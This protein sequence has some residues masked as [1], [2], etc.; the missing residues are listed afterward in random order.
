MLDGLFDRKF[1]HL[2]KAEVSTGFG[3]LVF[4]NE[5]VKRDPRLGA[6]CVRRSGRLRR[7]KIGH[8]QPLLSAELSGKSAVAGIVANFGFL[9]AGAEAGE[10]IGETYVEPGLRRRIISVQQHQAESTDDGV[11][12]LRVRNAG[13]RQVQHDEI[14]LAAG[15][16]KPGRGL[17]CGRD[18]IVF[19]SGLESDDGQRLP[20]MGAIA[21]EQVGELSAHLLKTNEHFMRGR[22]VRIGQDGEMTGADENPAGRLVAG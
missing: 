18:P 8:A 5:V 16:K 17:A 7:K 10:I 2:H 19:V 21:A 3:K 1:L 14:A 11:P 12:I 13:T 9:R 15:N 20:H 6:E 22:V 4:A